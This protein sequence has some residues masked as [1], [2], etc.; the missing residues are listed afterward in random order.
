MQ[1]LTTISVNCYLI[2]HIF[3][4]YVKNSS[5]DRLHGFSA[6]GDR[7]SKKATLGM[8]WVGSGYCV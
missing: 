1:V 4:F 3:M 2:D 5:G 6:V 7:F 8:G